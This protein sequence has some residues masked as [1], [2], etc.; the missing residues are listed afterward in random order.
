MAFNSIPTSLAEMRKVAGNSIDKKYV[1]GIISFYRKVS[2]T[3]GVSNPLAFNPA[4][5]SGKSAKLMRALKGDVDIAKIKRESKLDSNFKITWGDGSRGNRGT[6]NTG[7]LFETQL[8]KGLNDWVEGEEYNSNPY[9]D[10]IGDL[11]KDYKLEDCQIVQVISEGTL[12]KK[13]P[14]QFI[15][16]NWK[17]G[18]ADA[19]NYDI[20]SV[21]TDLTLRTKCKD[22]REKLIYLSLKKGG[23]TTMSNLGVKKIFTQTDIENGT[24]TGT[25]GEKVLETFG[26]E[27]TRFCKIFNEAK[28]GSVSSGGDVANPKYNR[29]LLESMIRGSI[30]YGYHYA[31]KESGN[32][33]KNFPMKKDTCD[34][35]TK[36]SSVTVH[37]GGRTGTGQRVDITVETPVMELKFNIRDTSGSPNPW[38]DKL[39]SGYKF[40]DEKIYSVSEDGYDD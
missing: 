18:D 1:K 38:P 33:I 10:F 7:N 17:I 31:H 36:V 12:N 40:K 20:G 39:Q 28:S 6:G 24:I 26:I 5:T 30:G 16:G 13:R 3:H 21:V 29:K 23:T 11:V 2:E 15:G 19:N 22:Q 4:V 9:K 34:K 14:I 25:V 27:N 8:E 32:K 37:Y 35:A